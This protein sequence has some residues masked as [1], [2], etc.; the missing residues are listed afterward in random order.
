MKD[1]CATIVAMPIKPSDA[2]LSAT[3]LQNAHQWHRQWKD[4]LIAAV[5]A[6]ATID[7]SCIGRDDCCDLGKWLYADGQRLHW[8]KPEFQHLLIHHREFHM[9]TGAVAE[10]INDKQ[11]ALAQAYLSNDTQLARASQ[12]VEDAIC[13]LESAVAG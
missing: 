1:K 10:V 12:E 7:T 2:A 11:F 4:R 6:G 5:N 9:L 8:K 13:R 3:T